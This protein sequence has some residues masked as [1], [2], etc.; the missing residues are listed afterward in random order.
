MLNLINVTKRFSE[1][2]P[3]LQEINLSLAPGE[4]CIIIGSNGSGKSTLMRCISGQYVID[5]GKIEI[6]KKSLISSVSQDINKGTIPEMT[7]LENVVLSKLSGKKA[8]FNFYKS[9]EK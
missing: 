9:Y 6:D 3:A 4:F 8:S 2:K 5:S 7:L 1:G